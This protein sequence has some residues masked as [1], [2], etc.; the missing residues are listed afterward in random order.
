M[1]AQGG[2]KNHTVA[3]GAADPRSFAETTVSSDYACVGERY[4]VNDVF[5]V[6]E[7]VYNEISELI[8]EVVESQIVRYGLE[9]GTDIGALISGKHECAVRNGI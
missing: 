6:E 8:V 1:L 4:L 7:S 9:E 5:L 2:A 3:T